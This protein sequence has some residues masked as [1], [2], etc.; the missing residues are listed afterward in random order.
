MNEVRT[1]PEMNEKIVGILRIGDSPVDL[2]A[3][4]RIEELE[5]ELK[6]I[7]RCSDCLHAGKCKIQA[8]GF[9]WYAN[10]NISA[11]KPFGCLYGDR[12]E[13]EK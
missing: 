11:E 5:A 8:A 6:S 7:V 13:K 3:A 12:R 1:Y 10:H 9:W 2:Y 4:K